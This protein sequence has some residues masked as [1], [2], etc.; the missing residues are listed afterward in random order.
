MTDEGEAIRRWRRGQEATAQRQR[1][2][3]AL[4]GPRPEQSIAESYAAL[5]ALAAMGLWPGPPDAVSERRVVEVRRRWVRIQRA[6]KRAA[7]G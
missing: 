5:N 4:E 1:E 7:Q 6:S 2:L 3:A